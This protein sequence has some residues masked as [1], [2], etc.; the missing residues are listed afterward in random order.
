MHHGTSERDSSSCI[1][2]CLFYM[3]IVWRNRL[4]H[5]DERQFRY[6]QIHL[7]NIEGSLEPPHFELSQGPCVCR[8]LKLQSDP[9]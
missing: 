6:H 5:L 4:D 3:Q 2:T 9:L 7:F 8:E 1:A